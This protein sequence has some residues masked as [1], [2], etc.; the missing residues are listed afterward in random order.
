MKHQKV[1]CSLFVVLAILAGIYLLFPFD[2]VQQEEVGTVDLPVHQNVE[3]EPGNQTESTQTQGNEHTTL[4]LL[5]NNIDHSENHEG[6]EYTSTDLSELVNLEHFREST[7]EHIFMGTI[8][9]SGKASGYHYNG[10]ID[11]P[12]AIV[13]GTETEPDS[14]GVYTAQ[15]TVDGIRKSGNKG[16]S[17][18]FPDTMS[19]QDVIDAINEAYENRVEIGDGLYAGLTNEGMEIDMA[20]TKKGIIV[21]AYPVKEGD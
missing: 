13:P 1:L 2:S 21:T 17:T 18:F 19:P 3:T 15:V 14:Y 9:D 10:I 7:I 20:L 8:N 4:E 12:G 11:S 5:P 16:Y 6:I